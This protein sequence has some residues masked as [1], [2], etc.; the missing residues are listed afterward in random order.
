[1]STTNKYYEFFKDFETLTETSRIR[2]LEKLS[3]GYNLRYLVSIWNDYM[4]FLYHNP[5]SAIRHFE[6]S[7]VPEI[8]SRIVVKRLNQ[9][10]IH[11]FENSILKSKPYRS[12]ALSDDV[13]YANKQLFRTLDKA[14]GDNYFS[15]KN[16]MTNNTVI[17]EEN[18]QNLKWF[19]V[20]LLFATGEIH[21]LL[22]KNDFNATEVAKQLGNEKGYRPYITDT[23]S[24]TTRKGNKS[25]YN[26]GRASK[27]LKHC[28]NH[29]IT[30]CDKFMN[31]VQSNN[32]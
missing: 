18:V 22:K 31:A 21:N 15:S 11:Y 16:A 30:V 6:F 27:I 2:K 10:P 25:I 26:K 17:K 29:N 13:V 7:E 24:T 14:V 28:K 20:G 12:D 9:L 32:T 19:P 3:H 5:K 23:I 1:M 8:D 4:H